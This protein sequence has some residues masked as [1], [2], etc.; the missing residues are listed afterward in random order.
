MQAAKSKQVETCVDSPSDPSPP[1]LLP[2][3][4][5]WRKEWSEQ[6][7]LLELLLKRILY[8]LKWN[9]LLD[10]GYSMALSVARCYRLLVDGVLFP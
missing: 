6:N 1:S 2:I 10:F 8:R 3:C 9:I 7:F 5:S 4:L